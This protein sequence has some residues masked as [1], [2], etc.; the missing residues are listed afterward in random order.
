MLPTADI[1][2]LI[3]Q[4]Q[5]LLPANPP[6]ITNRHKKPCFHRKTPLKHPA[7][8]RKELRQMAFFQIKKVYAI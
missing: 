8:T 5:A 4:L 2:N 7:V 3:A 6:E 1:Q